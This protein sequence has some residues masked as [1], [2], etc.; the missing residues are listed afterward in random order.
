METSTHQP[1]RVPITHEPMRGGT[2]D[3]FAAQGISIVGS[4][5]Q[6]SAKFFVTELEKHKRLVEQA[7][8][9]AE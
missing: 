2:K 3:A 9:K 7:K 6:T 5:P 1:T 8:V 4:D